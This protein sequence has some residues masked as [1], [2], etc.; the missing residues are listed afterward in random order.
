M[1]RVGGERAR[2]AGPLLAL[3]LIGGTFVYKTDTS[4]ISIYQLFCLLTC[5]GGN[6][7]ELVRE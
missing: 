2:A 4:F 3:L 1:L 7:C 6:K 5:D